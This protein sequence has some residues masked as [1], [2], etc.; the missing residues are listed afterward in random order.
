LKAFVSLMFFLLLLSTYGCTKVAKT[1]EEASFCEGV[2]NQ[3]EQ[4]SCFFDV[5]KQ[6]NDSAVCADITNVSFK[7]ECMNETKK[8]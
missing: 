2:D 8:A 6:T 1:M 7:E 4:D 3:T 5:A